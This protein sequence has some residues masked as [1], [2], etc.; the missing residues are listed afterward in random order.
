MGRLASYPEK[1]EMVICR[2]LR[3]AYRR[4]INPAQHEEGADKLSPRFLLPIAEGRCKKR[5]ILCKGSPE[6]PR[7]PL[8][9]AD[10]TTRR[11][12]AQT[13]DREAYGLFPLPLRF[14]D[15]LEVITGFSDPD[16]S[17]QDFQRPSKQACKT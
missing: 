15:G 2:V 1:H 14:R 12:A 9:A 5:L 10:R 7:P 16:S 4:A 11:A 3:H 6:L 8:Y 17:E 13:V